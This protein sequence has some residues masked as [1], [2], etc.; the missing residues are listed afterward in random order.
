MSDLC[1][2]L[3]QDLFLLE[4]LEAGERGGATQLAARVAVTV[5]QRSAVAG[6][7]KK[8]VEHALRRQSSGERQVTAGQSLGEAKEVRHHAFVFTRE[9]LSGAAETR[10]HFIENE[11]DVPLAAPGFEFLEHSGRPQAHA[12]SALDE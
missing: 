11:E 1:R 4:H 9:H 6:F 7:P 12:R 5:A 2:K 3:L 10:H 8:S